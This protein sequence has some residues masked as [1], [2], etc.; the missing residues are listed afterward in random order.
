MNKSLYSIINSLNFWSASTTTSDEAGEEIP[1]Y[2]E[3]SITATTSTEKAVKTVLSMTKAKARESL[4]AIANNG[5]SQD[6]AIA[7]HVY[8]LAYNEKLDEIASQEW[9]LLSL[10]D[11]GTIVQAVR[12]AVFEIEGDRSVRTPLCRFSLN[13]V[14]LPESTSAWSDN[15]TRASAQLDILASS[16]P[17]SGVTRVIA[18]AVYPLLTNKDHEKVLYGVCLPPWQ[19][20]G[21]RK[22]LEAVLQGY[23]EAFECWTEDRSK[24]KLGPLT[25]AQLFT[26]VN[27]VLKRFEGIDSGAALNIGRRLCTTYSFTLEEVV[28]T[29]AFHAQL[30]RGWEN[31]PFGAQALGALNITVPIPYSR[32]MIV[33]CDWT[34]GFLSRYIPTQHLLTDVERRDPLGTFKLQVED[35]L[36]L[37]NPVDRY[38]YFQTLVNRFKGV[39]VADPVDP[40]AAPIDVVAVIPKKDVPDCPRYEE[41]MAWREKNSQDISPL[42]S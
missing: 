21:Y 11:K 13:V 15:P 29:S 17:V 8:T 22:G 26:A 9:E 24:S 5:S 34:D 37:E 39:T 42:V 12:T 2:D 4:L 16:K 28:L 14:G 38:I 25:R 10:F 31:L 33:K 7:G 30:K 36:A 41:V 19:L 35:V 6:K 18:R 27:E 1:V 3:E 20:F 32:E 40:H 23:A